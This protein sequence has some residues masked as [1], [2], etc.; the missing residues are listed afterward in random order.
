MS[1]QSQACLLRM[2]TPPSSFVSVKQC[3]DDDSDDDDDDDDDEED[4]DVSSTNT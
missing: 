2:W 4:D 3:H 1:Q